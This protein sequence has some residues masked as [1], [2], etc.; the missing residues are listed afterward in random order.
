V[1]N[2][3]THLSPSKKQKHFHIKT[4]SSVLSFRGIPKRSPILLAEALEKRFLIFNLILNLLT[5]IKIAKNSRQTPLP[6][7]LLKNPAMFYNIKM[8]VSSNVKLLAS[9]LSLVMALSILTGCKKP[10]D[11]ADASATKTANAP[12][13]NS[14]TQATTDDKDPSDAQSDRATEDDASKTRRGDAR[15]SLG[16]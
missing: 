10:T 3:I 16:L 2:L 5:A 4:P 7:S 11:T 12:D 13:P 6:S 8:K 14:Q 9:L 15:K 1:I